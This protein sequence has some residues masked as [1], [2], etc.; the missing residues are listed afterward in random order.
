MDFE[1]DLLLIDTPDGGDIVIDNGLMKPD[2]NF[3]TAVY[4]SL[5]GGNEDDN[6]KVKNKKEYWGNCLKDISHNVKLRSR[7]Q[8]I[9]FGYPMTV[10]NI[11][12]AEKAAEK[13][14]EWFIDEK[15]ADEIIING[16]AI[17]IKNF[18]LEVKILKDVLTIFENKYQLLWGKENVNAI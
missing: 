3:S 7:F 5:F 6:G 12:E 2:I 1:G 14:L 11:K 10:K 15:I 18:E 13:D 8:N 16:R 4:L 9:I 17:G